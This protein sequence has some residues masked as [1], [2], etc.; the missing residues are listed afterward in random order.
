M[1]QLAARAISARLFRASQRIAFSEDSSAAI[2]D[3]M[4][5]GRPHILV[6]GVDSYQVW[7]NAGRGRFEPGPLT[8]Y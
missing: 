6:A 4:G 1:T 8:A 3:L 5:D 7:M 2:G